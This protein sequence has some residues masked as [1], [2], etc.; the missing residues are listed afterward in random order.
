MAYMGGSLQQ[1]SQVKVVGLRDRVAIIRTLIFSSPYYPYA[2]SGE[3]WLRFV[4][5]R[6]SLSE[7]ACY[8]NWPRSRYLRDALTESQERMA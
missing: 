2:G 1:S 6:R 7:A 4:G 5:R 3:V 8:R